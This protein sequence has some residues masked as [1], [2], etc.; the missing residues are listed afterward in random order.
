MEVSTPSHDTVLRPSRILAA[1]AGRP[2][3]PSPLPRAPPLTLAA[4]RWSQWA[5]LLSQAGRLLLPP[6]QEGPGQKRPSERGLRQPTVLPFAQ[7]PAPC[8]RLVCISA[9]S[10]GRLP[11]HSRDFPERARAQMD[12][13]PQ[14]LKEPDPCSGPARLPGQLRHGCADTRAPGPGRVT[15]FPQGPVW[16]VI[17]REHRVPEVFHLHLIQ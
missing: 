9:K 2:G 11:G 4:A 10:C 13:G 8:P 12:C 1:D 7:S 17:Q 6:P 5:V 15:S 3:P 14:P 16:P